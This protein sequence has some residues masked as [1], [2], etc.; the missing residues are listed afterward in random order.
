[1]STGIGAD[2]ADDVALLRR[3]TE[4]LELI[5]AGAP[6]TTVLTGIAVTLEDLVPGCRCS[7][8]L[9]DPGTATL[10]HG[11]AP[12]L[13]A[14][15]LAGIDGM[16]IGADAGSC[17]AAAHLGVA[18]VAEDITTDPRWPRYRDLA[19]AHALRSCWSTPIRGRGGVVG[20][21]AVYHDRRHRPSQREQRLVER[22]SHL[23]SVAID[24]DRLFG[25][26]A[27]SEE[28]F[29]RAFDD[30]TV[31]MA[32][33]RL[34]GTLTR[35][36]PALCTLLGRP[37]EA[38]LGG[39]LDEL[40]PRV[41]TARQYETCARH[42]DGHRL[43]LG[44][45]ISPVRDADGRPASLCVNV[46]DLTV[47]RAAERERRRRREA[48]VARSAAEAASRAKSDFVAA[49]GH[50]LRTPLQ[51]ITG[52]TELLR[53]LELSPE[54]RAAALG[55]IESASA[56]ILAM[57]DDVLDVARIEAGTV[58]L[59]PA[60]VD[61]HAVVTDVLAMVEPLAASEQVTLGRAGA[62][63][64]VHAD[65]RRCR[66]ILLNVVTNAIRYN[67]PGGSVHVAVAPRAD[68]G[69]T[70]TVRDTGVGIAPDHL[71]RLFAPF[72]RL[73]ADDDQ[74]VGLGLPLARGLAEAMGGRLTVD[75][76]RGE[77]TVVELILPR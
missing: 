14:A 31:G 11:G 52:F 75:S 72:D 21:F 53:T 29:R 34:D 73:G 40:F 12:S 25:A 20:T 18:V 35:V 68:G 36:N 5:A 57:V 27:D 50:E 17:G 1:V 71:E 54:R 44:V 65:P 8:L 69:A 63:A 51:A 77:G 64:R 49:L 3:Q 45:A 32:L 15:Y 28:R 9:I 16:P 23:A 70:V 2:Q 67:R 62:A 48:E 66:Q 39:Q 30:N 55:H 47:R 13:P 60:E 56:H 6:L 42:G 76:T 22:L 24:H 59:H 58:A 46:S 19:A 38:L 4:L 74:G 37:A 7:V 41:A 33:A 43:D 10:R 26:L 61:L